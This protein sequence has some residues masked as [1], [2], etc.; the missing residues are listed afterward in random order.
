M[1]VFVSGG[2][3]SYIFQPTFGYLIGFIVQA[4]ICGKL[5]R[6]I[7]DVNFK[8]LLMINF[9]GMLTVYLIGMAWFYVVSNF[10]INAPIAFWTMIFYSF[11]LQ[12]VPDGILCAAAGEEIKNIPADVFYVKKIAGL[13]DDMN[14]CF[15]YSYKNSVSPHLAAQI[16]K[17]PIDF[18]VI[19]RDFINAK[20][21]YDFLTV[22][23]SGGI[24]CPLES[25]Y[26]V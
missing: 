7:A 20:S 22:K 18:A 6:K 4:W 1:P 15:S 23:G 9:A 13:T 16:E 8:N 19:E 26:N 21:R 25:V 24:I 12:V 10:V 14:K 17:R 3:S 2:G 11:V 5:S